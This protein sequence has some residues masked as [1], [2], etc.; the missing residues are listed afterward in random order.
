[1][2]FI[3]LVLFAFRDIYTFSDSMSKFLWQYQVTVTLNCG[4]HEAVPFGLNA[5]LKAQFAHDGFFSCRLS[6]CESCVAFAERKTTI[7]QSLI[8]QS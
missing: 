7:G 2:H 3:S 5:L 1:M 6:L 4:V 8:G